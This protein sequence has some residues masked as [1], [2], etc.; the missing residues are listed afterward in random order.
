MLI[1]KKTSGSLSPS[2]TR[3]HTHT[4]T[5]TY[6]STYKH[7]CMA[8]PQVLI[9]RSSEGEC[10]GKGLSGLR[11]LVGLGLGLSDFT[12]DTVEEAEVLERTKEKQME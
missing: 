6:R 3:T 4:H 9:G 2:R 10:G 11:G 12:D 5:H 7:S 1:Q 8:R